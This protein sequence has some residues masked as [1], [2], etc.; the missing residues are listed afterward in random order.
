VVVDDPPA[1]GGPL[2]DEREEPADRRILLELELP[3]PRTTP[4]LEERIRVSISVNER[5]PISRPIS[6]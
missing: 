4:V 6:W 3:V 1:L 2:H 5:C